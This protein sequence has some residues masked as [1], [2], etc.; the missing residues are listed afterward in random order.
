MSEWDGQ[1]LQ[2]HP[3][4]TQDVLAAARVPLSQALSTSRPGL[5]RSLRVLTSPEFNKALM[6][7]IRSIWEEG[8]TCA[9]AGF[10]EE[11]C[12]LRCYAGNHRS[13]WSGS[14]GLFDLTSTSQPEEASLSNWTRWRSNRGDAKQTNHLHL[15][16][17]I[18]ALL[19]SQ[20]LNL[21]EV[22]ET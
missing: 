7:A 9:A 20:I 17:E 21:Q 3:D 14:V 10:Q 15:A 22:C 19:Q 5:A 11:L 16:L 12:V 8:Q 18:K 1:P 13:C 6:A 4:V 2:F